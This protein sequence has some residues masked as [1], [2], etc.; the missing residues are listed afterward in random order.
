MAVA[1]RMTDSAES[2]ILAMH[3]MHLTSNLIPA[4]PNTSKE[5]VMNFNVFGQ[6]SECRS[7]LKWQVTP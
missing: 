4:E 3:L 7:I 2:S 5:V 6:I 1:R